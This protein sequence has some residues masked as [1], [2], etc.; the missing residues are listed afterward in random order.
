MEL[1]DIEKLNVYIPTTTNKGIMTWEK[2][3]KVTRHDPSEFIYKIRTKQNK[4]VKVVE[5]KSLLI[6]NEDTKDFEPKETLEVKVG[7]YVPV[8]M[9]IDNNNVLLDNKN[10]DLLDI[11]VKDATFIPKPSEIHLIQG[12]VILDEII[13][14]EK[15]SSEEYPK[16]YDFTVPATKNFGLANGLQVYDTSEVGYIQRKL[17]KAMEDCKVAYDL[18]VRNAGG[19][20]IQFLYGEDAMSSTKLESQKIDYIDMDRYKL[21]DTYLLTKE[22]IMLDGMIRHDLQKELLKNTDW[23]KDTIEFYKQ[24]IDD[25]TFLIEK[26]FKM[27]YESKVTYPISLYRLIQNTKHLFHAIPTTSDLHPSDIINELKTLEEESAFHK[28]NTGTKLFGMLLRAYLAPKRCILEH[29]LNKVSFEYILQQI[30]LKFKQALAHPSEMVGVIAAQS[31]G[32]P[33]TQLSAYKTT[34]IVLANRDNVYNGEIGEFIDQILKENSNDVVDLGNDSVVYQPKEDYHIIGVSN[35]E[36]TKWNRILEVSRHK[37]HGNLVKVTTKTG[38]ITT[39]TLSHSFLKRTESSI[40]PIKGSDLKVGDRIPCAKFIPEIENP[41][42]EIK[43][44]QD[45]TQELN[46]EFGKFIGSYLADGSISGNTISISK[47]A[48]EVIDDTIKIANNYNSV[49]KTRTHTS[50]DGGIHINSQNIHYNDKIYESVSTSFNN[51]EL[52]NFILNEFET[53]SFKKKIPAWVFASNK[54]F[55]Y[56]ILSGYFNGDGNV[57]GIPGKQIIRCHSVNEK[58]IIDMCL[59]LTYAGIFAAKGIEKKKNGGNSLYTLYITQKYAQTFKDL[60]GF[61]TD[62]KNE[63]LDKVIEHQNR[64]EKHSDK[65]EYD[66]I[67]EL[68]NL[69]A[70]I[71]KKLVLPG[72]SRLYGRWAK[73]DSIGRKTLQNYIEIF[74][75]ANNN[76]KLNPE[77]K[78]RINNKYFNKIWSEND[79]N[80]VSA[81]INILKQ[82]AY[83]DIIWDEIVKLD[84]IED[85]GNYVYDFTVPGNDSFMVD[86]GVL[87]HNTLNTFHLSGVSSASQAVRGV[88]RMKELISVS[89]KIKAP[90]CTIYLKDGINKDVEKAKKVKNSLETTYLKDIVVSS[91][92]YYDKS[93]ELTNI[94]DDK[95]FLEMYKIFEENPNDE[96]CNKAKSPW[97]LRLE[98]NKEVMNDLDITMLDVNTTIYNF[99]SKTLS[100]KYSDD[101]ASKLIARIRINEE[102]DD[103]ITELKALEQSMLENVIIKGINGVSKVVMRQQKVMRLI[104]E[105]IESKVL[106][107][108]LEK[109]KG[110][111]ASDKTYDKNYK[112]FVNESEIVLDTAGTNLMDILAHEDIDETR[113]FSNDIT[114]INEI[115][116]IE[117]A[118]E[119]LIY[120]IN[121]VLKGVGVNFR[122]ISLLVDTMTNKGHLLSIDRH[123]INRSDIGPLA[124]SSFEETADMVLKAGIFAEVDRMTGVSANI[125]CGQIPCAGTGET[126]LYMD[127]MELDTIEEVD[128]KEGADFDPDNICTEE[129]LKFDFDMFA[130]LSKPKE[131]KDIEVQ[132]V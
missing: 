105:D 110:F 8:C 36:K 58:L 83:S 130:G 72:Q 123:G 57:N 17:V 99:Y 40:E 11:L 95:L 101:N 38:K 88:P 22:D 80:E 3:T 92:I 56:G 120:E 84:I 61:T 106:P 46:K 43:I 82:A 64:E 68:G 49:T 132:V 128:E 29:R 79:Y 32:E 121:D 93:D 47:D 104:S 16:V 89:K 91:R 108:D 77:Y 126:V 2:I 97:L 78:E 51:K 5:S 131:H 13:S 20:I 35:D 124:K 85:D 19:S 74:E 90:A 87:V 44:S 94:E 62:Y 27:Q 14:I 53:G 70:Y 52:A 50:K 81:K 24:I 30:R 59:L 103:M 107:K 112:V 34:K 45:K 23:E 65:E 111:K 54:E 109:T 15:I 116:G 25:R 41:L 10:L 1:L 67:P 39:A 115:F 73:K 75:N 118:R 127:E 69:I 31:I 98:F 66:K 113:T 96:D 122:H 6:W 28:Y 7:D 63:D 4:E 119:A 48:Q 37:A 60:I 18:T 125:I 21:E 76:L 55:I 117:A 12:D 129:G 26:V 86:C 114:E 9:F 33:T 100:C 71:G 102:F 42:T